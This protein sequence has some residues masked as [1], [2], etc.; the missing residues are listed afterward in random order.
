MSNTLNFNQCAELLNAINK[1]ATGRE[2]VAIV[3][4][5]SFVSVATTVL[6]TGY[7]NVI[8]AISTVLSKTIFSVRPYT[9][10][11]AELNVSEQRFG[12]RVRKL[13][14]VDDSA[15]NDNRY[16]LAHG[17]AVDQ[18]RVYKP[19]VIE[20][21]F[22]GGNVYQ[23]VL[24]VF[25]DQL[26]VA[27]SSPAEF[28]AFVSMLV[29]NVVDLMEKDHEEMARACLA[30]FCAGKYKAEPASV[31]H[32]LT[33]YNEECGTEYTAADIKKPEN[34][35]AFLM[36]AIAFI[37]TVSDL[38]TERS[39]SFHFNIEGKPVAKHT[40]HDKQRLY[41][42][43][44]DANGMQSR[45]MPTVFNADNLRM[46]FE[47]ISFWQNITAPATIK[48]KP[49]Y[50]KPNGSLIKPEEAE[51]VTVN[52]LFAVL[53]DEE[54]IGYTTINQWCASAPFNASGGYTNTFWHYTDRY[55]NDFMEN[56]AIFLLD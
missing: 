18:Q 33:L 45:V 43:S 12:A 32:L 19:T 16:S 21:N 26:D 8:N 17:V 6:Q 38:M 15:Q 53:V 3:D 52:N 11:F 49:V 48:A 25:K 23:R 22:Y 47:K 41:I 39:I 9:R 42:N 51:E 44:A 40:P 10:K 54:A 30:N 28:G 5:S 34:Y 35:G 27:F 31:F 1:Q 50:M 7:D 36:W 37:K 2:P 14:V 24:T 55:W 29:Q 20:S 13:Q 4:T 56:G 46:K